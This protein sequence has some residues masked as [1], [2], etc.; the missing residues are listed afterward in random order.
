MRI[1]CVALAILAASGCGSEKIRLGDAGSENGTTTC[2]PG[3]VKA[4]E[5]VWLGDSWVTMPGIQYKHVEELARAAKVL[6]PNDEYVVLAAAAAGI[7]DVVNQYESREMGPTKVKVLIMDGGTWDTLNTGGS[8]A[9]V[10]KVV[11]TFKQ[12]L[13]AIASDGTVEH[14][15]YYLVPE[16]PT[17][18]GVAALRPQLTQACGDSAVPCHFL[19]LQDSWEASYT[20][21]NNGIQASAAGATKIAELVWRVLREHCIAQ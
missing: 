12:L 10:A 1:A 15:V 18:Q 16:L 3:N 6:G 11:S 7:D 2:S 5:V 17:I 8:D 13:T 9:S 4:N 19:N 14:I 20:D 21:P